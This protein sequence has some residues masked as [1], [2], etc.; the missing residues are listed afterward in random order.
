MAREVPNSTAALVVIWL[1]IATMT[2]TT[3]V[4]FEIPPGIPL[5]TTRTAAAARP[6]TN[7][8]IAVI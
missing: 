8:V 1:E 4:E 3:A 7:L 6:W 2:T 5:T